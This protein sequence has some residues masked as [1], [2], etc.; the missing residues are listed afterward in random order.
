MSPLKRNSWRLRDL[1]G[2]ASLILVIF[3]VLALLR[4]VAAVRAQNQPEPAPREASGF[5]GINAHMP[6]ARDFAA[7]RKAGIRWARIDLTW[8]TVEPARG[9]FQWEI[10]DQIVHD[11]QANGVHLVAILG[12]CPPW[13]SSGPSRH[14]PPRN[15]KEWRAF[16]SAIVGRYRRCIND[17]I[18]WNEPNSKT[19]FRGSLEQFIHDV[20]IPG[21]RAAK[22]ANPLCRIVGPDLAHLTGSSWDKWLD[23]ILEEAGGYIDVVSHH[24]YKGKPADVFRELD[25][26]TTFRRRP[27]VY[28]IL[29]KRHMLEKPFWLTEVGWRSDRVGQ[30]HQAG[31]IISL[32][33]RVQRS[34]WIRK[35]FIYDL[36]DSRQQVGYGLLNIDGSPKESFIAVRGFIAASR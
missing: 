22:A 27:T 33:K 16:V 18:L 25:G 4:P 3:F 12:Y 31:Y 8:D 9:Q 1:F 28:E 15:R 10:V 13:A 7:M 20:F 23:R 32:L 19:F 5:V 34:A 17:W 6:T 26:A 2:P 29:K 24:C 35:V 14:D 21:A 11:A 36:R 30:D